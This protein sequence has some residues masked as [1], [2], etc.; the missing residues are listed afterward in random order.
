MNRLA[1]ERVR[2]LSNPVR[3]QSTFDERSQSPPGSIAMTMIVSARASE[4]CKFVM[5]GL[6][7]LMNTVGQN[8]GGAEHLHAVAGNLGCLK[9]LEFVISHV[10]ASLLVVGHDTLKCCSVHL[11][12]L[13]H[14]SVVRCGQQ[15]WLKKLDLR[16]FQRLH[17]ASPTHVEMPRT[18][19]AP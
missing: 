19:S 14:A 8:V 3:C 7:A 9:Q 2:P 1:V 17:L 16:G 15:I 12:G 13:G 10:R 6:I 5:H 11:K 4:V 18:R